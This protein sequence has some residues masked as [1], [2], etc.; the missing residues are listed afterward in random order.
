MNINRN[1][2]ECAD[3][4]DYLRRLP[5]E[6]VHNVIT[7]PPYYSLRD[8][9]IDGQ[10]G[11]ESTPGAYIARIVEVF[12]EVRRV[13]RADG[14]CWLNIGDSYWNSTFI[15]SSTADAFLNKGDDGY[16]AYYAQNGG[17]VDGGKRRSTK[18]P[19]IK[20]KD[21]MLMPA[22]VAIALQDSGWYVRAEIIWHKVNPMPESVTDRPTKAHEMVYLLSKSPDYWYDQE[23]VREAH[24]LDSLKRYE[25]GLRS[26]APADGYVSAGANNPRAITNCKRMG[27]NVNP[28]GRNLR[29]V[30][31]IPSE[32]FAGAH[33]A[34]FP[35]ALVER[36]LRAGCPARTCA[37]CGAP[38]EREIER[39]YL[40]ASTYKANE[41]D[42]I[43]MGR[44]RNVT[45]MGDGVNVKT[46]GFHPTCAHDHTFA[47]LPGIVL[48]P[49]MGSG[50]VA[51]VAREWGRDYI[52]CDLSPAYVAMAQARLA[53][54]YTLPMEACL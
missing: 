20:E 45:R 7:S 51:L 49:F 4:L 35:R 5:D 12:A 31:A 27:D 43:S 29:D 24:Q 26:R 23:A 52:G 28:A 32:P 2:I 18:H 33:F 38:W 9:G 14:T 48:D 40:S 25:Y 22:R 10:I 54:P 53:V 44:G 15:R 8:Y 39:E 6:C 46:L 21:L 47:T 34:T 37:V 11:L 30:W 16:D 42:R 50:T 1:T 19:T 41:V 36:C 17:G 3:A 13:L